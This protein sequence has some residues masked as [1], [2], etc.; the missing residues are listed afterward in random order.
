M[1]DYDYDNDDEVDDD[2]YA[3]DHDDDVHLIKGRLRLQS[4]TTHHGDGDHDNDDDDE[5]D[6][7]DQFYDRS[8]VDT[9][10]T[11]GITS[12]IKSVDR[13]MHKI[14]SYHD[15]PSAG[16]VSAMDDAMSDHHLVLRRSF[17]RDDG[18]P[19]G[20]LL[21]V[22]T[23]SRSG[24][25]E[26]VFEDV[27]LEQDAQEVDGA[28]KP[29][30]PSPFKQ[31]ITQKLR[32]LSTHI[33]INEKYMTFPVGA[34]GGVGG[35][36]LVHSQSQQQQ[37]NKSNSSLPNGGGNSGNGHKISSP[38]TT[39]H[40]YSINHTTSFVSM[41][42]LMQPQQQ[43]LPKS[44]SQ[45]QSLL[46]HSTDTTPSLT[47][48]L[49]AVVVHS[50]S[51]TPTH[52]P[53]STPSKHANGGSINHHDHNNIHTPGAILLSTPGVLPIAHHHSL[54][55]EPQQHLAS[56]ITRPILSSETNKISNK[57]IVLLALSIFFSVSNLYY[58][59]PLLNIVAEEFHVGYSVVA[60]TTMAVQ[61]GYAVG[62]LFI[63]TLGD[64]IS[65]KRLI[66]ILSAS[67]CL[68]LVGVALSFHIVQLIIFQ[69]VVGCS[70]IIPH[71]AIPLAI[72]LSNSTERTGIL[73]ILM[74]SLFVGLL[75]ARVLSGII[76]EFLDWRGVYYF[77]SIV[78][79]IISILLFLLLPY[80]P[81][82]QNPI[83]YKRLL[84]SIFRLFKTEPTLIQTSFIGS[85]VFATFSILWTTLSFR[86]NEQPFHYSSGFIGLFGLIGMAG[87]V[88]APFA[89]RL[90]DCFPNIMIVLS[91]VVSVVGYTI[92]LL[93]DNHL[94]AIIAG[95]FILDLGV[96]SC[97]ITNQSRN[98]QLATNNNRGAGEHSLGSSNSSNGSYTFTP[99]THINAAYMAS[100][101]VGGAVG[102][103]LCGV[104]YEYAGWKGSSILAMVF[105]GL[106]MAGHLSLYKLHHNNIAVDVDNNESINV[107]QE[108]I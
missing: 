59:Q 32:S 7:E 72:D 73:S 57:L 61:A 6:E 16:G 31:L 95:I 88:T 94:L 69:F 56:S 11:R 76:T 43:Q 85:A 54:L 58:I 75:G 84:S 13:G 14:F 5:Y 96:Q 55:L 92:L 68:S 81:R 86:L 23:R 101:F 2:G 108:I 87:A 90:T 107:M 34:G 77:A 17:G 50:T 97:H 39:A 40:S 35:G 70:T 45:S 62:L 10:P 80:T 46:Q 25:Q 37:L 82:S 60:L 12:R 33:D 29:V 24:S 20:G 83:P 9:M 91:L 79:F 106:A 52:T 65:K 15:I 4:A 42:N 63:S 19:G 51:A 100:Y 8:S 64:I 89:N 103:G 67:S 98:H 78:M 1:D 49:G 105:L 27:V 53:F 30:S 38:S 26:E 99:R 44:Q 66:L 18:E 41:P 104:V 93:F 3:G 48:R 102:S 74:S 28:N 36:R 47:P 71:I 21:V 22:S